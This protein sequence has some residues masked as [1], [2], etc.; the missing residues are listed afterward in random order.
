MLVWSGGKWPVDQEPYNIDW[1]TTLAGDTIAAS[2]WS[3][4]SGDGVLTI[5]ANSFSSTQTQ[6]SL[7]AGTEGATYTLQNVI[8]TAGGKTLSE[9]VQLPMGVGPQPGDLVTLARVL[10]WLGLTS[11]TDCA[12]QRIISGIS[13]QVTNYLGYSLAKASYT[14]TF[15]GEG[16]RMLFVPD[17]PL[18]SV[19]AVTIDGLTIPASAAGSHQPG[20]TPNAYAVGLKGYRFCRGFQNVT[21]SYVAGYDAMPEDVIQACLNWI[22]DLYLQQ[23]MTSIPTNVTTVRAG[24][25]EFDFANPGTAAAS[26]MAQDDPQIPVTVLGTLS[27]YK[28]VTP[29]VGVYP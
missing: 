18:V 22:K 20:F 10:E 14:R 16:T 3:V 15:D 17:L 21:V 12:V 19:S 4:I 23:Q 27:S 26:K 2:T 29:A 9:R 25:T 8:T 13:A 6:V 7:A 5:A 11:D 1:T 28:R 24:D